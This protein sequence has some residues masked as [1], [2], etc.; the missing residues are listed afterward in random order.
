MMIEEVPILTGQVLIFGPRASNQPSAFRHRMA[1]PR[2][3]QRFFHR[4][5]LE[6]ITEHGVEEVV[7]KGP[8]RGAILLQQD[9]VSRGMVRPGGFKSIPYFPALT[10]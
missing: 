10:M 8:A 7:G 1:S 9:Y 3:L 2:V 6:E 5:V 4:Q